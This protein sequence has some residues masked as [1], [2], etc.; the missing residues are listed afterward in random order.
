[1]D[2]KGEEESLF[3]R[4]MAS[5][6]TIP[7]GQTGWGGISLSL[8]AI[9]TPLLESSEQCL[10]EILMATGNLP[11][12]HCVH[13]RVSKLTGD[14]DI[15]WMKAFKNVLAFAAVNYACVC[16][17][18]YVCVCVCLDRGALLLP[19]S[20][21]VGAQVLARSEQLLKG[22]RRPERFQQSATEKPQMEATYSQSVS[23]RKK[24]GKKRRPWS[25]CFKQLLNSFLTRLLR[26][27]IALGGVSD[28]LITSQP[29]NACGEI[30]LLLL[31][32]EFFA[33]SSVDRCWLYKRFVWP[34]R[35]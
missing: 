17:C 30:S 6:N 27:L 18:V 23:G 25:G 2:R 15:S 11:S 29:G 16:L 9:V 32:Q 19:M 22:S 7:V 12:S 34:L 20:W 10:G 21:S 14:A 4:R 31:Y 8:A 24:K 1:M 13:P 33:F 26:P 35:K 28:S 5:A 3:S